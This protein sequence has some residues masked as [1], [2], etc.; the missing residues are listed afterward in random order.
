VRTLAADRVVLSV[1][2]HD[3]DRSSAAGQF[4]ELTEHGGVRLRPWSIRY[5]TPAQLDAMAAGAGFE[6]EH[7]WRA[8]DDRSWDDDAERHVSVYRLAT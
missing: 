5:A 2:V 4:V 1:S 7:R 3:P 8:F 6:L